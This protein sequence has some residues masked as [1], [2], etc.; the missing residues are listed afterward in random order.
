MIEIITLDYRNKQE[1]IKRL[2][3]EL[4]TRFNCPV[5]EL[6]DNY[7]YKYEWSLLSLIKNELL[8]TYNILY[9]N[10]QFWSGSGGI[11]RIHNNKKY[12][13][14]LFRLFSNA[15]NLNNGLGMSS[16][17]FKYSLP[18]QVERAKILECDYAVITFNHKPG[19]YS[20][21]KKIVRDY[22]LPKVFGKNAFVDNTFTEIFN[23]VEQWLLTM[24]L[25]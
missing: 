18:L 22:H 11:I 24:S 1:Y 16:H 10:N 13:Q 25:K 14:C 19:H 15:T 23:G 2:V 12:Y 7:G 20:K 4:C 5:E 8:D 21:L 6:P 9:Y 3:E 17:T